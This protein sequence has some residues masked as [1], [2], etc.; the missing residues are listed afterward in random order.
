[1]INVVNKNDECFRWSVLAGLYPAKS[2]V[3]NV[4]SYTRYQDTLNFDGIPFPVQTSDIA[5]FEKQNLTISVNVTS[6]DDNNKGFCVEYLSPHRKRKHHVNLLLYGDP[7]GITYHYVYIM[8]FSRLLGDRTKHESFD[9]NS[10]F[11]VFSSQRVLDEH[12][13]KFLKHKPQ[14]V[15]YPDPDEP[16]EFKLRYKD[17]DKEH[18]HKFYLVC[19]FESFL[20]PSCEQIRLRNENAHHR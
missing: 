11:N 13:L 7:E 8:N 1:M 5:K 12:F 20:V 9:C 17:H 19:D 15:A 4:Y 2:N 10:C 6:L 16:D 3:T 18:A 14:Q